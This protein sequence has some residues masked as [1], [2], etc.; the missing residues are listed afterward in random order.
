M[1]PETKS[2][3]R[4]AVIE[5][6][7]ALQMVATRHLVRVMAWKKTGRRQWRGEGAFRPNMPLVLLASYRTLQEVGQP[8]TDSFFANYP[9]YNGKVGTPR[10]GRSHLGIR[11][12]R[13]FHSVIE[14]LGRQDEWFNLDE[15]AVD[16]AVDEF[17]KF[18]DEPTIRFVFRAL[19]LNLDSSEQPV[20]L[21][22]GLR[23]RP[24]TDI[25]YSALHGQ[26]VD[27]LSMETEWSPRKPDSCVEGEI[28]ETKLLGD[29]TAYMRPTPDPVEIALERLVLSMRTFKEGP[30]GFKRIRFYPLVPCPIHTSSDRL[31]EHSIPDGDYAL[32]V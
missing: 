30:I 28:E 31:R 10:F 12:D 3:L 20:D 15:A 19:L 24:L 18:V 21:P 7:P 2:L 6:I 14:Y 11:K 29:T 26:T 23:I 32:D 1:H 27:S 13:I 17:E 16:S 8:F 5:C 25:E 22:A 4:R 9:E